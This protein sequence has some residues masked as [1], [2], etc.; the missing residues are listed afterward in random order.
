[1]SVERDGR[2]VYQVDATLTR[3]ATFYVLADSRDQAEQDADELAHGFTATDWDDSDI[4]VYAR[5]ATKEPR[6][7]DWYWTG[8]PQGAERLW[9]EAS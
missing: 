2:T 4:D 3:T 6:P 5:P 1:M 8:G 9:D 7:N